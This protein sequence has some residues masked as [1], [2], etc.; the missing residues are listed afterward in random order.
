MT[1]RAQERPPTLR[2][3]T[4]N[5]EN[6]DDGPGIDPPLDARAA[7]LRPQLLQ[8]DADVL[9][10]Q[11]VSGQ[12]VR[13]PRSLAALDRLIAGTPYAGFHRASTESPSGGVLDRQNLV[14]LSRWPIA[15]RAQVHHD[16][17][18]PLHIAPD[19]EIRWDRP[20][21]HTRISLPDG[22]SLHA[23][24]L[25]LRAPL[26]AHVPGGKI[27]P[28]SWGSVDAWAR[29][30]LQAAV[31][32]AGQALEARLLVERLFDAEPDP[33]IV[34]SGD[35]NAET[36]EMP[37]RLLLAD[38]ADTGNNALVGRSLVALESTVP[39]HRRYSVIHAGRH[40]LLD[41]LLVSRALAHRDPQVRIHNEA[42]DDELIGYA[43]AGGPLGSYHAPL[44]VAFTLDGAAPS[45]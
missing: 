43:G 36:A 40:V 27:G 12:P 21:L 30:C 6:L 2:I 10:L 19:T 41:H 8:L 42:L 18:P 44:S 39:A 25:H 37:T 16:L 7:V 29:G 23:L 15:E 9:L 32:R 35:F 13:S 4:F 28:F 5:L 3:A 45:P 38:P 24:N 34:V 14:T 26:A 31:K 11:E 22:R 17:V 1:E 33:W 20:L